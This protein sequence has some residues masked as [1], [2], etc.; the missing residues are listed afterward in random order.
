MSPSHIII[1]FPANAITCVGSKIVTTTDEIQLF[2][3]VTFTL[4]KPAIKPFI[5]EVAFPE[6]VHKYVYGRTPPL[7]ETEAAPSESP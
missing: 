4:Y 6:G 7:A 5:V 2:E 1:L 3:S